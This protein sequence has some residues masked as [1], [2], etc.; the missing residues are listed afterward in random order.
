[1][2]LLLMFSL[3][4]ALTVAGCATSTPPPAGP[5]I[6]ADGRPEAVYVYD[7]GL[8]LA[9]VT[10][11]APPAKLLEF[12][13]QFRDSVR[14]QLLEA[15]NRAGIASYPFNRDLPPPTG[16]YWLVDVTL[17]NI[18]ARQ[19]AL[20]LFLGGGRA[21]RTAEAY[22]QIATLTVRPPDRILLFETASQPNRAPLAADLP[23]EAIDEDAG[24]LAGLVAGFI[25][26]HYR[27]Q[28]WLVELPDGAS[29]PARPPASGKFLR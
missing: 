28:G 1:M 2:R 20:S 9:K 29:G 7:C 16:N 26:N 22:V 27:R 17:Y 19:N 13:Q 11:S 12:K 4:A 6:A 23:R 24:R 8:D 21:A 14:G 3:V 10:V 25:V 18:D 5:T 15:L